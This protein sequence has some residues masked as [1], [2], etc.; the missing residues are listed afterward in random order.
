LQGRRA[1]ARGEEHRFSVALRAVRQRRSALRAPPGGIY[2]WSDD[3]IDNIDN[4]DNRI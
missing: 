4:I 1:E 3:R 2:E